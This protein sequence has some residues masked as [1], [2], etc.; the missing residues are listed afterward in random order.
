MLHDT[1]NQ[2]TPWFR[3]RFA[4]PCQTYGF[5]ER[6]HTFGKAKPHLSHTKR[7]ANAK[8]WYTSTFSHLRICHRFLPFGHPTSAICKTRCYASTFE[9]LTFMSFCSVIC[10]THY[11]ASIPPHLPLCITT[12]QDKPSCL[13]ATENIFRKKSK[14][15]LVEWNKTSTFAPA[16]TKSAQQ[17][18]AWCVSSVG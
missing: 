9:Q 7:Y 17:S 15:C 14:K 1:P 8:R 18:Y 2:K 4:Y 10:K 16:N 11:Y 12:T 3:I 5:A 13:T 6:N